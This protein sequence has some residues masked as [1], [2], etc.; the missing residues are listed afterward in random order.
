MNSTAR[1]SDIETWY[2]VLDQW[3]SPLDTDWLEPTLATLLVQEILTDIAGQYIAMPN[4]N[5]HVL[6]LA[7]YSCAKSGCKLQQCVAHVRELV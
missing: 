5:L 7:S 3:L 6:G 2:C 4:H 1:V